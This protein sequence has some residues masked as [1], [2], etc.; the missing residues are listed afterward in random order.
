[1][2]S[3]LAAGSAALGSIDE[4]E[5]G[6]ESIRFRTGDLFAISVPLLFG[7]AVASNAHQVA[8]WAPV[9]ASLLGAALF[10]VLARAWAS[11]SPHPVAQLVGNF[12]VILSIWVVYSRLN[13]LIDLI[14]PVSYDRDLQAI[15]QALF[16]V[17]PSVWLEQFARPWLTE[18]LFICYAAF[19]FWQLWLGVL[20]YLR[21]NGDFEDYMTTVLVFYMLSYV[22]YILVPAVG[23]RFDIAHQYRVDLVGLWV[24][25]RI[26]ESF[27]DIP[28][29]RDCFPSG[30]TGLTLLVMFH[31]A[32]KRAFKF[33][34][35]MAPFG[36]LLIFST[37]YCRFHYAVDLLCA[38]PFITGVLLLQRAL[39]RALPTGL[40]LPLPR[41]RGRMERSTPA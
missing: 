19:F 40:S 20:L 37:L 35:V 36:F 33:L 15:D 22:M 24:G 38:L 16:G 8:G 9:V 32:Q 4:A 21:R 26:E 39:Q 2:L 31:A 7:L 12:Y 34:A 10:G 23:P 3:N 18:L 1:M 30:H 25:D 27:F 11:I 13:P 6:R 41:L 29:V 28:M 17:Q 14:S 5:A